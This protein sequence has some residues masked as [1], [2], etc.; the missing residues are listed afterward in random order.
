MLAV[1]NFI[2]KTISYFFFR[3]YGSRNYPQ[4][5]KYILNFCFF[6]LEFIDKK[7]KKKNN[8]YNLNIDLASKTIKRNSRSF[9]KKT[10]FIDNE[11][12]GYLHRWS[13]AINLIYSKKYKSK[14]HE[15]KYI[16]NVINNWFFENQNSSFN[17]TKIEWYPY[18]VSERIS[19]YVLLCEFKILKKNNIFL[20]H[21]INQM[22]F[23]A[24][25]IEFYKDKSSN[26]SLNNARAIFLLS[27]YTNNKVFQKFSMELI[28]YL[29][30]KF[31]DKDGFFKFGSSHY[32]FVFTKW[33]H[34]I[35][36][37]GKK[38][39]VKKIDKI[40]KYLL[41]A[42]NACEFFLQ[43]KEMKEITYPLFGNISPDFTP[44]FLVNYNKNFTN[45]KY[46]RSIKRK[47][48]INIINN[49]K[50]WIR[51][52]NKSQSVYFRNPII[53][54]FDFN[55]AHADFFHFVNFYK[56]NQIFID[57]G[58]KDYLMENNKYIYSKFHNSIIIN[59]RGFL[60]EFI[61]RNFLTKIGILNLDKSQYIVSKSNNKITFKN[62]LNSKF[63]IKRSFE[64]NKTTLNIINSFKIK[65]G[66]VK[67]LM[68]LY[69]DNKITVNKI[70]EKKYLLSSKF[71]RS[72]LNIKDK[73][74]LF[75]IEL[76]KN[77]KNS[78][79]GQC[80]KYGKNEP[81]NFLKLSCFGNKEFQIM[82]NLKFK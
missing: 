74:Q 41:N 19:N 50:E 46:F 11:D 30:S 17:R 63:F 55:H 39:K 22:F 45:S 18:N 34:E 6:D 27:V 51:L 42:Q 24:K 53:N 28:I 38:Y 21:L 61:N 23:L 57:P 76:L 58:R 47:K 43:T 15:K 26:H 5:F 7:I 54:G 79:V 70:N 73:N 14:K 3:G 67:I 2:K 9:W 52:T 32:Q 81:L 69:L 25:N 49:N 29:C 12:I 16:E 80:R 48:T 8:S 78:G 62:N 31:I 4:K 68:P 10:N 60:E 75:K 35:Y 71:F 37:F 13:W 66:D 77:K 33:L 59:D 1:N 64:L 72:I 65:N 36:Y 82:L 56:G 44:E 20:N 40:C